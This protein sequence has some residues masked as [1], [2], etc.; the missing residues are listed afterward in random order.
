MKEDKLKSVE[1]NLTPESEKRMCEAFTDL[2]QGLFETQN[3]DWIME[4]CKGADNE[5]RAD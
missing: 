3:H 5:Q 2:A 1:I 4:Y